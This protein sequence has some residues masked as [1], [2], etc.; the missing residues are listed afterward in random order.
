MNISARRFFFSGFSFWS[1]VIV[2]SLFVVWPLRQKLRFG[3]DIV[4]GTYIT[5]EVQTDKAVEAELIS[6]MQGSIAKLKTARKAVPTTSSV[7][8]NVVI[9]SFE[10]QQKAEDAAGFLRDT[11][12]GPQRGIVMNIDAATV[13]LHFNEQRENKIKEDA[14]RSNIN[15]LRARLDKMSV[16]EISIMPHGDKHIIVELPDVADPLQAKAMIGKAAKLEFR[17]VDREGASPEDILYELGD[18]LPRDKEIL[19]DRD[20]ENLYYLVNRYAEV[21]GAHLKDA[22]A[23]MG[24]DSGVEAV[25]HF[26]FN[27]E[28]GQKFYALTSKNVNRRLAVV[29]DGKVITAPNIHSAIRENGTISGMRTPQEAHETASLLKSGA[30]VAPV[31][32]EEERQTGPLLGAESIRQGVLACL[33]ALLFLLIVCVVAYKWSGL[34]AFFVLLINLLLVLVGMVWLKATL[35]LPGIGGMI[36][37][38]GMA[39][40]AS[41]LIFEHIRDEIS[42]GVTAKKAIDA[43]FAGALRVILDV[44]VTH[45]IAGTVLYQ[46]GSG[47]VQGFAVTLMFGV[48]STMLTGLLCLK[49][50]F[51][52]FLNVLKVEKLSI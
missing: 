37:T 49:V 34:L 48:V 32:F 43:G 15:V 6:V 31:T 41:I 24:G 44:N 8:K 9:F 16:A 1:L 35:T 4:G 39:V 17:L 33:V 13:S 36:L 27:Q 29:L 5:L 7:D 11:L 51:N 45:L 23:G 47:P 12:A 3:I 21:T 20:N 22:R 25:V 10:D 52:F 42:K 30:F 46:F 50:L 26:S 2:A 19:P 40:D 28:G 38:V 14:V 18:I